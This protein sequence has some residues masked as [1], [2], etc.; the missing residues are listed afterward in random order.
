MSGTTL[1]EASNLTRAFGGL[2]AVNDVSL[3]VRPGEILGLIGPNGAGKTTVF[4]MLAGSMP[5]TS[6]EIRFEGAEIT[7]RP[8]HERARLGIARTFQ[9]TSVFP[10]LT[11]YEN[12]RAA[13]YRTNRTT[14]WQAVWRTASWR[15]DEAAIDALARE[16]LEFCDLSA[17]RDVKADSLSYGEQRRLEVAIALAAQPRLLLLDEP[18]AGLNP[19]EGQRLVGMIRQV[20]ERGVTVLLVEHHMRVVMGVCD[21]IIVLD[22]GA[23]IAEGRPQEVANHPDVIRVYLGRETVHA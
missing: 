23:L 14:W 16:V 10:S 8:A 3:A 2:V 17:Q 22:H 15:Q 4:N 21:R 11:T 19:E 6:G 1:L 9:I 12:V 7:G 20:R 13:T 18:A 5:P